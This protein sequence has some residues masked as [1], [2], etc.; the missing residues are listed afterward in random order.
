[1]SG[2]TWPP[3]ASPAYELSKRTIDIA[4]AAGALI[5]ISPI[6]AV[7]AAAI[8][9]TTPGPALYRATVIGRGGVPFTYFKFRSMVAGDDSHHVEWL[10]EFVRQDLPYVDSGGSLIYKAVGDPRVTRV[11]RL[12]RR[13]SLDE[14]PQLLNVLRGD[15]SLVGPR[16]PLPAEYEHY[17]ERAR[18]RLAV[19]P[20]ITG[21]YQVTARSRVPFSGML[22][23]DL[24]YIQRRSLALDLSIL[25][26][27]VGAILRGSGA[28]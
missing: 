19:L 3:R 2:T 6:W 27:T 21:L 16:P 25:V 8:R 12:L 4:V 15:M 18:Q 5:L 24:E 7:I 20:G 26:R 10:R 22:A 11:G 14:V 1:V 28:V 23:L 17:D 13:S 9:V